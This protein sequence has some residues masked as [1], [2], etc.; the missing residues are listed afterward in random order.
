MSTAASKQRPQSAVLHDIC[1]VDEIL[2]GTGM[3]ARVKGRQV[4][5]FNTGSACYAIGNCDPFSGANVLSRGII[6][7]LGG[8]PVVAS[9]VYKQHFCLRTG[10]CLE[11]ASISVP[12]W[13]AAVL[14]GRIVLEDTVA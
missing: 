13:T 4:A 9:P 6:G 14:D 2:P 8:K 3:A 11:D 5:I 10:V 12:V 7:D 1:A